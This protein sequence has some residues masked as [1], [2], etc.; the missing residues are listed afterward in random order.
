MRFED[1][2]VEVTGKFITDGKMPDSNKVK[3]ISQWIWDQ[4]AEDGGRFLLL[5]KGVWEENEL[6]DVTKTVQKKKKKKLK[7]LG[8]Y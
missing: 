3:E 1:L 2:V 7:N 5:K 4:V 8:Q 6:K